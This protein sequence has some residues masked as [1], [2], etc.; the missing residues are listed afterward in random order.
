MQVIKFFIL[1]LILIFSSIIGILYSKRYT[2][3]VE[4]L[5]QLK[6]SLNILSTKIKFTYESLPEIFEQIS[7]SMD[8]NIGKIF[9]NTRNNLKTLSIKDAWNNS[10]LDIKLYLTKEDKDI[11]MDLGRVLR[12]NRCRWAN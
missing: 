1:F 6:S 5:K 8:N 2:Y 10:I 12:K 3:R 7:N 9:L 11:I 4:E